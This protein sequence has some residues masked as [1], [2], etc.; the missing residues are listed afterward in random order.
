MDYL[1][2]L[3]PSQGAA[4]QHIHGPL[5][6][7]AGAGSG[8][9]RVLTYRIAHMIHHCGIAPYR[10]LAVTFTNKAAQ[11]MKERVGSI[12]GHQG[13]QAW[14]STFHATCVK[15]LRYD[16]YKIG[17]QQNFQ[18]FDSSDQQVVIKDCL[19]E[20]NLDPKKFEPRALLASIS[21]AK[22]ELLTPI[23]YKAQATDFWT[24]NVAK[25]YERYQHK[26]LQNNGFD[27]D[28]LIMCTVQLFEQS[29]DVLEK[30]QKKFEYIMV[31]EYQDTNHAQYQLVKQL[32]N[33]YGNL[34]VVGDD[35]Q[36]IY[37]F[38]GADIRN[39]LEFEKDYPAAKVVKLEENYRSTQNI[40]A[41]ANQVI[42]NNLERKGKS[43]WTA[44]GSG[45]K[46]RLFQGDDERHEAAFITD[47]I[48]QGVRGGKRGY[49][50]YTIL[51]RTHAQSRIIEEEFVRRGIPYRIVSGLRFY[52]RK[53]IKDVIAYLR[54]L[55]NPR[56]DYSLRR[57]INV[58]KRGIGDTTLGKLDEYAQAHDLTL[59]ESITQLDEMPKISG[60]YQSALKQFKQIIDGL[61]E[62]LSSLSITEVVTAVLQATGYKQFLSGQKTVE[63]EGRLENVNEFLT[64]TL[65]FEQEH[66]SNDLQGFLEQISLMA[67]VDNYDQQAEVITMMTLHAA[68]GLEF[69]VVFLV[70]M[71][72]GVFPS[73]RSL[74]EPGQI[75]EERRLAYVGMTR[76]CEELFLTCARR[77]TIFGSTS[78]NPISTFVKEVPEELLEEVGQQK[79]K[80]MAISSRREVYQAYAKKPRSVIEKPATTASSNSS[81]QSYRVGDKVHHNQWG[82]G[83]IVAISGEKSDMLSVAFPNQDIK[84]LL[85][86][87]AP[88]E[89]I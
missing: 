80:P 38:R 1:E 23:D 15:I 57:I 77:R 32:A 49:Q 34:C 31:D 37:A 66:Q 53:E 81:A 5:L 40:L 20:L 83:M 13:E 87:V 11:E 16:G 12:V 45:D 39:I 6:I 55:H 44:R 82:D 64:V 29:P 2:G 46:L 73:V 47:T 7:I 69:P 61:R 33:K 19:K 67:D 89:K 54:L 76:A 36:S 52:D 17:Y 59:L 41:A 78:E 71:E 48:Q 84:R 22:N 56:D 63:A 3:N 9:T 18:I 26:L 88:L 51:Y 21:T 30:Y 28:D 24:S 27:F 58:P 74:W 72:D 8:K 4:V 75:E 60:K 10:I 35:D 68:K 14:V 65:R 42:K 62:N 85:A 86:G 79:A 43:L 50:D 25:V 70:G